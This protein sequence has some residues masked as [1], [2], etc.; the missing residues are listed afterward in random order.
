MLAQLNY[1]WKA[2]SCIIPTNIPLDKANDMIKPNISGTGKYTLSTVGRG[3]NDFLDDFIQ[4][5]TLG[6]TFKI[7]VSKRENKWIFIQCLTQDIWL[8]NLF[9]T[10]ALWPSS[11]KWDAND[12]WTFGLCSLKETGMLSCCSFLTPDVWDFKSI[13]GPKWKSCI[14]DGGLLSQFWTIMWMRIFALV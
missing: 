6:F 13:L 9:L 14:F 4:V 11:D 3:R 5:I 2:S 12:V 8:F 1:T 10:I 7:L